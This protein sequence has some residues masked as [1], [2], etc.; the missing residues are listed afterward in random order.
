LALGRKLAAGLAAAHALGLA[1][2]GLGIK[3]LRLVAE[4]DLKLDLTGMDLHGGPDALA[5]VEAACRAPEAD[6]AGLA[7]FAADVYSLGTLLSWLLKGSVPAGD[8]G[9]ITPPTLP[10][11]TTLAAVL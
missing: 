6:R 8:G 4:H 5:A 3:D 1:H 11:G 7:A 9:P 2:G 10:Q